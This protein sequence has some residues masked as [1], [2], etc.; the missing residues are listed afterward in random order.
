MKRAIKFIFLLSILLNSTR[1]FAEDIQIDDAWVREAPPGASVM[2]AYLTINNATEDSNA[3]I[4]V[5]SSCCKKVEIHQ[6]LVKNGQATMLQ[7]K[8]IHLP[9]ETNISFE[10]GGLHLM[11][12]EPGKRLREGDIIELEFTFSSH[13]PVKVK[14][15]VR[16]VTGAGQQNHNN[17]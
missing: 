16:K 13:E 12:I 10:P 2:A 15:A 3:L 6:S 11:L 4:S 1:I 14:A 8:S 9:A 7:R 17:H 5:N